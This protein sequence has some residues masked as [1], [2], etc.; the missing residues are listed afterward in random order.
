MPD[1][2]TDQDEKRPIGEAL[3]PL[4]GWDSARWQGRQNTENRQKRGW[5]CSGE[6]AASV[7][8]R[9]SHSCTR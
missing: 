7:R 8:R 9:E 1:T 5:A 2:G 6:C 3:S 4:E